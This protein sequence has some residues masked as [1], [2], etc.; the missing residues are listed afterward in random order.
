[1][2]ESSEFRRVAR[3]ET[4]S[5][6]SGA[7]V[8]TVAIAIVALIYV[9]VETVLE[10]ASQPAI[11]ISPAKSAEWLAALPKQ[12]PAGVVITIAVVIALIGVVLVMAALAPGRLPK[13]ELHAEG[14][15]VLAD[16]G[17]IAAALAQHLSDQTGIA[18]DRIRVGVSRRVVD[19]SVTPDAGAIIDE[20]LMT[21]LVSAE[22]DSYQLSRPLKIRMRRAER[23]EGTGS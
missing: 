22:V 23:S 16:N 12:Q 4:H 15:V 3:R 6:R 7:M 14:R 9:G 18:R 21:E 1:M 20:G 13:H 8:V 5:P 19:V 2:S 10:L 17:V 11:L